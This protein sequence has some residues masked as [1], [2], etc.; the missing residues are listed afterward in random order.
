MPSSP[1]TVNE[2][3]SKR[4]EILSIYC[5][6]VKIPQLYYNSNSKITPGK[7][8]KKHTM[9]FSKISNI[10]LIINI[11]ILVQGIELSQMTIYIFLILPLLDLFLCIVVLIAH[12]FLKSQISWFAS[13]CYLKPKMRSIIASIIMDGK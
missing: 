10:T 4:G 9:L 3:G 6:I 11:D 13:E 12:L 8:A 7:K 2:I 5:K 1:G